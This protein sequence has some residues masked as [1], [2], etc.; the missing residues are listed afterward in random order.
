MPVGK[1]RCCLRS[2]LGAEAAL[3]SRAGQRGLARH[4]RAPASSLLRRAVAGRDGLE[5]RMLRASNGMLD[6]RFNKFHDEVKFAI[7]R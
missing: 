5:Q 6:G 7:A 2:A 4:L 1:V 3:A